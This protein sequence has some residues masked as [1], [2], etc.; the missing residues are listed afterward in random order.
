[1][2]ESADQLII[3]VGEEVVD[4]KRRSRPL[5]V[6]DAGINLGNGREAHISGASRP[7]ISLLVSSRRQM[8]LSSVQTHCASSPPIGLLLLS[9][10]YSRHLVKGRSAPP[11]G[12]DIYRRNSKASVL[13]FALHPTE[14]PARSR[15]RRATPME[16]SAARGSR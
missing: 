5:I 1:M 14:H 2:P 16:N 9:C 8:R 11:R 15:F 12:S 7:T 10:G 13:H 6:L 4:K 3:P